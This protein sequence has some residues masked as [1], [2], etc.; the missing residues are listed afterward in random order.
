MA[1]DNIIKKQE[2]ER[3]AISKKRA[4][5]LRSKGFS[6]SKIRTSLKKQGY[7]YKFIPEGEK[8]MAKKLT[9]SQKKELAR[10]RKL[11]K[12]SNNNK[13]AVAQL[14]RYMKKLGIEPKAVK[15]EVK[16]KEVKLKE[17]KPKEVKPKEEKISEV[18][19]YPHSKGRLGS[20]Q[21]KSKLQRLTTPKS[22]KKKS[23][24]ERARETR[25][26]AKKTQQELGEKRLKKKGIKA[27]S[28]DPK[29]WPNVRKRSL[30]DAVEKRR[31]ASLKRTGTKDPSFLG[32]DSGTVPKEVFKR[33]KPKIKPKIAPKPK[34][35]PI[36]DYITDVRPKPQLGAGTEF[37]VKPPKSKKIVKAPEEDSPAAYH[38]AKAAKIKAEPK[39]KKVKPTLWGSEES[40]K[41]WFK[42]HFPGLEVEYTYPEEINDKK[43]GYLKKDLKKAK[44]RRRAALRGHRK[45]LRGG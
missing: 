22:D 15:K 17:V 35:K 10:K 16:S 11:V 44:A 8:K 38:A 39:P 41:S 13:I 19:M 45:E 40:G 36:G 12:D 26:A 9:E 5:Q 1:L 21:Q 2:A 14:K 34:R 27:K 33:I 23:W 24:V 29:S 25:K 18:D 28:P 4:A 30:A 37:A 43:G 42:K 6:E 20:F 31:K 7:D 32:A 3:L